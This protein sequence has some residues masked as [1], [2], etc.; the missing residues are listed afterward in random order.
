MQ[1]S[2]PKPLFLVYST[3]SF[4]LTFKENPF[5][6]SNT[7]SVET[8][9]KSIF[10]KRIHSLLSLT[11]QAVNLDRKRHT[12]LEVAQ[13]WTRDEILELLLI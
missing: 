5:V 1:G 3:V 9:K 13:Y 7:S 11:L 2:P 4:T 8:P 12:S 10:I 6:S